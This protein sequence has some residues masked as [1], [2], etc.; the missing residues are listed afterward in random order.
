ME[1]LKKVIWGSVTVALGMFLFAAVFQTA[2]G[3][4]A[5]INTHDRGFGKLGDLISELKSAKTGEEPVAG[6]NVNATTGGG[7]Q[8]AA[9]DTSG[10]TVGQTTLTGGSNGNGQ[11]ITVN[12]LGG[13]L[14]PA[15]VASWCG[16]DTSRFAQLQEG[17][18]YVNPNGVK[19]L[20]GTMLTCNVPDGYTIDVWSDHW[21]G[22]MRGPWNGNVSEASIRIDFTPQN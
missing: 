20:G 8:Q 17:N 14:A 15:T 9:S 12:T 22:T 16:G 19:L 4:W 7:S 18:G 11:T 3:S 2:F 1:G 13:G 5:D 21:E 6:G 10:T